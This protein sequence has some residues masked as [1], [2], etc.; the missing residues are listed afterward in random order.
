LLSVVFVLLTAATLI[1]LN[2][3]YKAR[4]EAE[5]A[6]AVKQFVVSLFQQ[7]RPGG[8]DSA[9]SARQLLDQGRERLLTEMSDQPRIAGQLLNTI[10]N[11]YMHLGDYAQA[12]PQLERALEQLPAEGDT[13]RPRLDVLVDLVD[14]LSHQGKT[15]EGELH[16]REGLAIVARLR[17][18]ERSPWAWLDANLRLE[19]NYFGDAAQTLD[20]R[21]EDLDLARARLLDQR[22][23]RAEAIDLRRAVADARDARVDEHPTR[24]RAA[25]N[26]LALALSEAGR[27]EEAIERFQ[28]LIRD[29]ERQY[30]ADHASSITVRHN[31]A[32][33]LRRVGQ[34]EAAERIERGNA[35]LAGRALPPTHPMQAYIAN[36]LAGILRMQYRYAEA[37]AWY[38]KARGVFDSQPDADRDMLATVHYNT[39]LNRLALFD[40]AGADA[41]VDAADTIWQSAFGSA[42]P[43]RIALTLQRADIALRAGRLDDALSRLDV[44]SALLQAQPAPDARETL[45]RDLLRIQLLLRR[46]ELED[47]AR[48][49]DAQ[50]TVVQSTWPAPHAEQIGWLQAR[51]RLALQRGDR[52]AAATLLDEV[53][54]QQAKIGSPML[55][56]QRLLRTQWACSGGDLV[57]CAEHAA[58][59]DASYAQLLG[60]AAW[61]RHVATGWRLHA[62]ACGRP[63]DARLRRELDIRIDELA[64]TPSAAAEADALRQG[65]P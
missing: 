5:R 21:A 10:G 40:L 52:A 50:W 19:R 36:T 58:N 18:A 28:R 62:R 49:A 7:A 25:Q 32:L 26:D 4:Q 47:A 46:G 30:G 17:R 3:A 16:A 64:A 23:A 42:Y 41:A 48:I 31:L 15:A 65:C 1:S 2:Q 29:N 20:S 39:S 61:Q 13:L 63:A 33:A 35:E 9:P 27:N 37:Q 57:R 60:E 51:A 55:P 22:G 6:E 59:A 11:A 12:A 54:D 24:V 44:A 38:D 56:E 8:D 53:D 34:L 14:M 45:R 43:R